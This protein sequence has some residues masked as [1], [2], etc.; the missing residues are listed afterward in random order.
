M[1][2]INRGPDVQI[3]IVEKS[4]FGGM[5]C[6]WECVRKGETI[7]LPEDIGLRNGLEKVTDESEE[8]VTEG[9]I[10]E[11]KVETKQFEPQKKK[12]EFFEELKKINGIGEKTA[13]DIV[14]YVTREE[15]IERIGGGADL[16]FRDDVEKLLR[17]EYGK[18]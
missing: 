13:K 14:N 7:D 6:R 18:Q 10:A 11:T 4:L 12:T 2:F 1:K 17:K 15:L 16:P 3:R 8:K 9:K 5:G